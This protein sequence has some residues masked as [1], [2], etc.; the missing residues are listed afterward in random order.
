MAER[1][2]GNRRAPRAAG[3][4][5]RYGLDAGTRFML[6]FGLCSDREMIDGRIVVRADVDGPMVAIPAPAAAIFGLAA[7]CLAAA[8]SG[9][10]QGTSM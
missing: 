6:L 3:R 2:A 5:Q 4:L 10:G 9:T 1:A 8:W 7:G